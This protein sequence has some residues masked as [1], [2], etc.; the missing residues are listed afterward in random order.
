MDNETSLP[1]ASRLGT[2]LAISTSERLP[3]WQTKCF[4]DDDGNEE[5]GKDKKDDNIDAVKWVVS[6]GGHCLKPLS[7][8]RIF[9]DSL[10]SLKTMLDIDSFIDVFKIS[11]LKSIRKYHR[12]LMSVT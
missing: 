5:E 10:A 9:L 8:G 1:E 2:L 4:Q 6:E 7:W 11:R 3:A 12:L